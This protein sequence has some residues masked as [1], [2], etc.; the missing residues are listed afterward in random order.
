VESQRAFTRYESE[1]SEVTS[2][3]PEAVPML[4]KHLGA[5]RAGIKSNDGC[6]A[7]AAL[8]ALRHAIR[9]VAPE[10]RAM[11]PIVAIRAARLRWDG[12]RRGLADNLAA[13]EKAIVATYAREQNASEMAGVAT[14]L[15]EVMSVLNDRLG[16]RLD[17]CIT[18]DS[19]DLKR[20]IGNA[21]E[22]LAMYLA[23]I[24]GNA[25]MRLLPRNPFRPVPVRP[26]RDA[27][28][29]LLAMLRAHEDPAS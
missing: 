24:E 11:A 12:L 2:T 28:Y 25:L 22:T 27:A 5:A 14:R 3:H 16:D 4:Q 15:R 1:V 23:F 29:D 9:E 6:A 21:T 13:L 20:A 7:H 17:T 10:Y 19:A 8:T 18:A 26:L